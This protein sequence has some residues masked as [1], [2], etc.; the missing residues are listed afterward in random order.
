MTDRWPNK[1]TPEFTDAELAAAIEQ[2]Q[3]D[4]DPVTRDLVASCTREWE[5]RHGLPQT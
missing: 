3:N 5:R 4:P 1:T 2:H